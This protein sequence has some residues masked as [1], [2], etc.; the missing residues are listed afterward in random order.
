MPQYHNALKLLFYYPKWLIVMYDRCFDI[1]HTALALC[2]V[3]NTRY[4][5]LGVS[6]SPYPKERTF[7]TC[8]L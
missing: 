7:H 8:C 4:V 1:S 5:S 2:N 3:F 6:K